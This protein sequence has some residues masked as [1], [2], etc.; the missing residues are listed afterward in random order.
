[1]EKIKTDIVK[2]GYR[3]YAVTLRDGDVITGAEGEIYSPAPEGWRFSARF[4][5]DSGSVAVCYRVVPETDYG[6]L[7]RSVLD[8]SVCK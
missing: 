8:G 4:I 5:L 3:I 7:I 1:M 2:D 6:A